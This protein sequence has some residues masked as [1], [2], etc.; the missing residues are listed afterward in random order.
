MFIKCVKVAPAELEALLIQHTDIVDAAVVGVA[1]ERAGEVPRAFVVRREGAS[2]TGKQVEEFVRQRVS[3]H[4]QVA[5]GVQFVDAI[6]KAASGK[7]L[8]RLLRGK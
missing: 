7:I 3:Q 6:P 2:L 1:D 4:K 5:G 8:R